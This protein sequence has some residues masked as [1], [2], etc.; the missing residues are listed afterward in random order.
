[1]QAVEV[2]FQ[3]KEVTRGALPSPQTSKKKA[4]TEMAKCAL[5]TANAISYRGPSSSNIRSIGRSA[6][7]FKVRRIRN[8]NC[9][10]NPLGNNLGKTA[11][12][13]LKSS[14]RCA[15]REKQNLQVIESLLNRYFRAFC[16]DS[17]RNRTKVCYFNIY[18]NQEG[19]SR[20]MSDD[21]KVIR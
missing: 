8:K 14:D 11:F 17:S 3:R 9:D 16:K 1:M 18:R 20:V 15:S 4:P 19:M 2:K 12:D 5:E 13:G 7:I 21:T 10:S 6:Q